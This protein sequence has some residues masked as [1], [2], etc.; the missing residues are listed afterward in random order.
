MSEL[1]LRSSSVDRH[2]EAVAHFFMMLEM[3]VWG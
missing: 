1:I 2:R 3:I